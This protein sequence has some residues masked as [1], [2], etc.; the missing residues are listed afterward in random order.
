VWSTIQDQDGQHP[1][2]RRLTQHIIPDL[3]K[4]YMDP[5]NLKNER[6]AV[7]HRITLKYQEV[8]VVEVFCVVR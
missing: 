8:L 2:Q 4:K 1:D 7:A 5:R 3:P 6:P